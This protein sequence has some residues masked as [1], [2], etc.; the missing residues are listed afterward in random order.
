MDNLCG[1]DKFVLLLGGLHTEMTANKV[2]GHWLE[3]SGWIE[4]L[5]QAE[6]ATPGIAESFL[7]A[8]HVTRT[9]HAHQ[10]TVCALHILL[11][12]AYDRAVTKYLIE[13]F[14]GYFLVFR[15]SWS[16]LQLLSIFQNFDFCTQI[17]S[18][19]KDF[20]QK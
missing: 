12:K 6:I 4:A 3:G 2:L 1:K 16:I 5:Q 10:V 11:R 13:Y 9:R 19:L 17:Q 20:N 14:L 15:H 7:K 8:S 18:K